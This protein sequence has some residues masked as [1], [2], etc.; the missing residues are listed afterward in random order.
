MITEIFTIEDHV[1]RDGGGDIS[2]ET[3]G[4]CLQTFCDLSNTLKVCL[5]IPVI[6]MVST[7]KVSSS[8]VR[9]LSPSACTQWL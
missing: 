9:A 3:S 7:R 2:K 1:V 6:G 8:L 5:L 4:L